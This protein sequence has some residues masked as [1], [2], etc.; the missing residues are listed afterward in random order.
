MSTGLIWHRI[1]ECG[2]ETFSV[3]KNP[4]RCNSM[5]LLLAG[6]VIPDGCVHSIHFPFD[7]L[8][9]VYIF[10]LFGINKF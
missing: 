4:T 3:N 9:V 2:L 1:N 8:I 5:L 6:L 10:C 7:V